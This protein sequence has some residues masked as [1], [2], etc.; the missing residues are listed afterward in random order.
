MRAIL[1]WCRE[2][3]HRLRCRLFGCPLPAPPVEPPSTLQR[4]DRIESK[5]DARIIRIKGRD[6]LEAAWTNQLREREE[7]RR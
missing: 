5:I 3:P 6:W 1:R 7:R 4:L 2:Y